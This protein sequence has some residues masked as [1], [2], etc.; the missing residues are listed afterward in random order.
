VIVTILIF[1]VLVGGLVLL[2]RTAV[3]QSAQDNL[4]CPAPA[5]SS[6]YPIYIGTG[7]TPPY[8]FGANTSDGLSDW[9]Q[10][11]QWS[12]IASYP[13]GQEWGT[14]FITKDDASPG[15]V[16]SDLSQFHSITVETRG[17][18]GGESIFIS[19]KEASIPPDQPSPART[20]VS[21]SSA[22]QVVKIPLSSFPHSDL[23]QLL[24]VF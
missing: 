5:L 19:V 8:T 21:L 15:G 13:S 9:F 1:A 7:V 12:I 6:D 22:W 16:V 24:V 10:D 11:T 2:S 17:Q 14:L 3:A 4:F 23:P 18:T 20:H